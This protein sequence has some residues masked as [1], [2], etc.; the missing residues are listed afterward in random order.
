MVS[1]IETAPFASRL[2]VSRALIE[3]VG[4]QQEGSSP[5]QDGF[6]RR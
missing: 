3:V 5:E 4:S 2:K 1:G 6:G